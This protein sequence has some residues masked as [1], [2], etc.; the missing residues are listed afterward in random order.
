MENVAIAPFHILR[1]VNKLFS[2]AKPDHKPSNRKGR[3]LYQLR[4]AELS[5]PEIRPGHFVA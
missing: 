5:S 4:L 1:L 2:E 3:Q